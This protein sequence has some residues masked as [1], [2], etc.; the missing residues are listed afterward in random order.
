MDQ[1]IDFYPTLRSHLDSFA[2][3][4]CGAY[5]EDWT[6]SKWNTDYL[7]DIEIYKADS[8]ATYP[9]GGPRGNY[10]SAYS[11]PQP[12]TDHFE[13][14]SVDCNFG[15]SCPLDESGVPEECWSC[16]VQLTLKIKDIDM[17]S[18]DDDPDIRYQ[19]TMF[20]L[21]AQAGPLTYEF[22]QEQILVSCKNGIQIGSYHLQSVDN[23]IEIT[24]PSTNTFVEIKVHID[25]TATDI[26]DP[27]SYF[28]LSDN[29]IEFF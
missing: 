7:P 13:F 28:P 4:G 3:S 14:T 8:D 17:V 9:I 10:G 15:P 12:I 18:N 25:L 2:E 11:N 29:N 1:T 24:E 27:G 6:T 19:P 22:E 5:I 16:E 21:D 26:S 23:E 20:Y